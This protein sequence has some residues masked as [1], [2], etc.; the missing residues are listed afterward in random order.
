MPRLSA[1]LAQLES[2]ASCVIRV[3]LFLYTFTLGED[4]ERFAQSIA[5]GCK[6]KVFLDISDLHENFRRNFCQKPFTLLCL[7]K[8]A[9][10]DKVIWLRTI[11]R[12]ST[13]RRSNKIRLSDRSSCGPLRLTARKEKR[14]L[15]SS[16]LR[17]ESG[18][19]LHRRKNKVLKPSPGHHRRD[20]EGMQR[21]AG[22][23]RFFCANA[24]GGGS[25]LS[26]A[27]VGL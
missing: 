6:T 14:S 5:K 7:G 20:L 13:R 11:G 15:I 24:H 16:Q 19:N 25:E 12:C 3:V 21:D 22:D 8:Y 4:L 18:A 2:H 1:K 23:L 26:I 9:I 17:R 10:R 27:K